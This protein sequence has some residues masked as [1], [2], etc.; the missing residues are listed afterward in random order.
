M[1]RLLFALLLAG[2]PCFV[3]CG[4]RTGL[5]TPPPPEDASTADTFAPDVTTDSFFPDVAEEPDAMPDAMPDVTLDVTP[6]VESEPDVIEDEAAPPF[7][8][9]FPDAPAMGC[10]DSAATLVYLITQENTLLSF[11]PSTL[12][13]TTIG[14]V[15]CPTTATPFSMAVDRLGIAYSVFS[16]GTL[17][18]V[19][20]K[21]AGCT[22]FQPDQFGFM[23]F[24][25]GYAT[26]PPD[27]GGGP[28]AG[29]ET[30]FVDQEVPG[31][32]ATPSVGLASIDT[33][34]MQM[35]FVSGFNPPTPGMELTGNG[36]GRLFGFGIHSGG[37]SHIAE[38]D[39]SN[40]NILGDN[41]LMVGQMND[42]WAFALWGGKF[43]VFTSPGGVTTVTEF[44]PVTQTESTATTLNGTVVGAGVSTCAPQ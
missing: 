43:W 30:L 44:D 39:P 22:A 5:L 23:T 28:D 8:A 18:R 32:V 3:A 24:G 33:T 20:T 25:M 11:D 6:D 2:P 21:N 27:A 35:H 15:S 4:S 1:A 29:V 36:S 13:P 41:Q 19:D 34:T 38:I 37:G 42:A 14:T 7:D 12:T 17:W 9:N 40:G 26:N 16:D 10:P 31:G